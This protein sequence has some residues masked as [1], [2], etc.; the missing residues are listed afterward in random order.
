MKLGWLWLSILNTQAWPS[1]MST[2]PAFSP[3]P[4]ITL[5]PVVGNLARCRRLDLYEQCSDHIT[6]KTPSSTRLGSR[7]RRRT[8][9]SYSSRLRPNSTAFSAREEEGEAPIRGVYLG[10]PDSAMTGSAPP[11]RAW[12]H[13]L[14]LALKTLCRAGDPSAG[15]RSP[16]EESPL[17]PPRS[18]ERKGR[19]PQ[20]PALSYAPP[21]A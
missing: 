12:N 15:R 9:C 10:A 14:A 7:F 8:M 6:E 11:R 3:G 13:P 5:G 18:R 21:A 2:T 20:A 4:W 1:P 17:I 16:S 19:R